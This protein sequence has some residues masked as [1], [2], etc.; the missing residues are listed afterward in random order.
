MYCLN[1]TVLCTLKHV[2]FLSG[3]IALFDQIESRAFYSGIM[4]YFLGL[5]EIV[6]L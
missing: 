1:I 3:V 4:P 2:A 6:P 5:N